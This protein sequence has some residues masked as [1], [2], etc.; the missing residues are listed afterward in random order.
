MRRRRRPAVVVKI[1]VVVL[2]EVVVVAIGCI[3]RA[4]KKHIELECLVGGDCVL[5]SLSVLKR[6][7]YGR[8]LLKAVIASS[9]YTALI[10]YESFLERSE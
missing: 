3:G 8:S 7:F 2:V 1:A 6:C 5:P 10:T 9:S 4:Q